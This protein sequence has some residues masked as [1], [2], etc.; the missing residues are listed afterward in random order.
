MIYISTDDKQLELTGYCQKWLA[1][2]ADGHFEDADK[3]IDHPNC[4]GVKWGEEELKSAVREYF[5]R[6]GEVSFQNVDITN[7]Y[8]EFLE[9]SDGSLLFGFY[10]PANEEVTDLTVQFEFKPSGRKQYLATI[11]DVHV[12]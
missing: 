3:L 6:E 2:L 9:S 10:L 4:Y 7:C 8:P 5:N 12:L 11:N 1:Y